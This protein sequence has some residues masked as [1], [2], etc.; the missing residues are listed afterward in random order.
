MTEMQWTHGFYRLTPEQRR[1][2]LVNHYHLSR[3]EQELLKQHA[4]ELGNDLVENYITDYSLPEGVVTSLVVNGQNYTVPLVTEEP[5]VIAAANNGAQRVNNSGGFQASSFSRALVGQVILEHVDNPATKMTWLK[6]QTAK[7][8]AI[9]NAAHPSMKRRGGG[10]KDVRLRQVGRFISVDLLIDVCQAMGANTVNTM[11][12]AVAHYLS[13]KGNH[14]VTAI[15]SNYATDSLQTVTCKVTYSALATKQLSG[16]EVAQRIVDLSDLAQVDPYRAAT[17]NKGIMNGID[18]ALIASGNDWRAIES[19]AHAYASRDGQYRGLSTW[20]INDNQL[21]GKLTLPMPVGV[22]G[23]SIGLNPLTRLDYHLSGVQ[24]AQELAAV[25]T[26]LG[27]AQNL[28]AIRALAT[29]GIQAGHMKLQYRSLAISVGA[30][31]SEIE[32]LVKELSQQPHVDREVAEQLLA[33]LRK[34][35]TNE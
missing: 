29:T 14:V 25:I 7:L 30:Q 27:L 13:A 8:L 16:A 22:V 33:A 5:S 18:A 20:R 35:S 2:I 6:Q 26:S 9:A 17:H 31:Q 28:A 3:A 34:G 10:A 15:L 32:Q 4:S 11:A 12:E 21:E 24:T 19:G 23:G 1:Q